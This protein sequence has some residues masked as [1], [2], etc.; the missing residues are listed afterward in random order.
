MIGQYL[1]NTNENATVSISKKKFWTKQGLS[2]TTLE[3]MINQIE[4]AC[5]PT[6]K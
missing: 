2:K 6:L 1:S 3:A 4:H 5:W